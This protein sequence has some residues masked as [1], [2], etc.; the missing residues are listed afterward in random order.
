MSDRRVT[1][2][3]GRVADSALRGQ[4]KAEEFVEGT[5]ASVTAAII[6]LCATPDGPRDRQ[7]L[8]GDAVRVFEDRQGW[9]FIQADKDGYVGYVRSDALGVAIAPSHRVSA[10]SSHLY[11]EPDFKSREITWLSCG[12]ALQVLGEADRFLETPN[13]FVP[14][15]HTAPIGAASPDPVAVAEAMIGAPYLWGGNSAMGIDCSGLVQIAMHAAKRPCPGDS[16]MQATTVG[17]SVADGAAYQ[18]GDLLF[19]K[20]HVA[21]VTDPAT[22]I[23]A[24]AHDMAVVYEGITEA[25]A[26]IERQGDGPVTGHRRVAD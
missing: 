7:L 17:E 10:R 8:F 16:D 24:N 22:L 12:S 5:G 14:R 3:N 20:G 23:H 19:W 26:R 13:G 11:S 1:P 18:R 2:A 6:D 15:R 4:V 21:L 25:I 9:S